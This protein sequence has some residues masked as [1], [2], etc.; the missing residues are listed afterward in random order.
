MT[1]RNKRVG[2]VTFWVT[3]RN[4]D[5]KALMSSRSFADHHDAERYKIELE[6]ALDPPG[7]QTE[8]RMV[9]LPTGDMPK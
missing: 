9:P 6:D 4:E 1:R 3:V 7:V 5:T 8:V 2:P